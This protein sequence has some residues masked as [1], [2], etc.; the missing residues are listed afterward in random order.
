M[1][2]D[3][4]LVM[5]PNITR[6]ARE[7]IQERFPDAALYAPDTHPD[8][9]NFA[10]KFGQE[11]IPALTVNAYPQ[12]A[13]N[14]ERLSKEGL[15]GIPSANLPPLRREL[16]GLGLAPLVPEQVVICVIPF[17]IAAS[18]R[19]EHKLED[20]ADLCAPDFPG[21]V[22]CPPRDTPL[23]YLLEAVV[24]HFAGDQAQNL[25]NKL[26]LDSMPIDLNK[27]IASGELNAA[28]VLPAFARS[29]RNGAGRM[30]WPR[31]GAMAVPLL[32]TLNADANPVAHQIL[33][34]LLSEEFQGVLVKDGVL[35]PAIAGVPAFEELEDNDWNLFWPGWETVLDIARYMLTIDPYA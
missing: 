25:L 20:W 35:V 6:R 27:R 1:N 14:V 21:P 10:N 3:V 31:S 12:V 15:F 23:P 17:I 33:A 13:Y 7:I 19:L 24:R 8:M 2:K 28:V 4:Y 34:F 18:A 29:F 30:I 22:G 11:Q 9:F 26:D 32:A 16:T 5:P